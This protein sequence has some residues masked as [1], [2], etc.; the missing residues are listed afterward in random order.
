[1]VAINSTPRESTPLAAGQV[2][3]VTLNLL[4]NSQTEGG[5]A[6]GVFTADDLI[7][8]FL[9]IR[10][11]RQLP[12]NLAALERDLGSS[13]TGIP[14]LEPQEIVD[15]YQKIT[16]HANRWTPVENL[17]KEQA[18]NL[19]IVA[20]DIVNTGGKIIQVIE[21]MDIFA[22]MDTVTET[23]VTIPITSAKDK[24]IQM[25]LPQV[26]DRLKQICMNQ[27]QK[28]RQVLTAVRD[29][30]TELSG[31]TLS[32]NT[33]KIG[34]EKEV[35]DK[36]DRAKK[37]NLDGTIKALQDSIDSLQTDIEQLK[38]DYDKYVGLVFSGMA[39]G[40]I[41][42]A[43]T[44]GIYGSKAEA[45]RAQRN[46]KIEEKRD[47]DAEL[48]QKQLIQGMLNK[49]TT[50]FT[51]IGMRLVDAQQALEDLDFLWTD[52]VVRID[53]SVEKWMQVKDSDMLMT[54]VT[55]LQGIVNPWKDVGNISTQ[56]VAVFDQAYEEYRQT[57]GE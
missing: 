9:Y 14:G 43:I 36:R 33:T 15:L 45:A 12:Q 11:A 22:Q 38:K 4:T 17:V 21:G 16:A 23:T 2:T 3:A 52:I 51:N 20:D 8:I 13:S 56:L 25:A 30:K 55:D 54:F 1:M 35:G 5:R 57:Y 44:S 26:I 29:Y 28:S 48:Q 46:N 32:D 47:K 19:T 42:W 41:G 34:L 50:T 7:N 31:G 39:G 18:S 37:A 24:K 27:Q 6:A 53:S 10:S 49:Y 40:L